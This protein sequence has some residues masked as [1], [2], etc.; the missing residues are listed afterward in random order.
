MTGKLFWGKLNGANILAIRFAIATNDAYQCVLECF[1]GA[2][3]ELE[4][5]FVS[6][7][8]WMYS[9]KQ[10][11]TRALE[12]GSSVQHSPVT[13]RDLVDLEKSGCSILIVACYQWKIPEWHDSIKYAV[14]FH[15][16]PLPEGRGPYPLVRALIDARPT[17]AVSCH[18]ITAK[19]DEGDILDSEHFLISQDECHESL[20][21]KIALATERLAQRVA[22]G[23]EYLWQTATPQSSGS[24]WGRWSDQDRTI[25]FNQTVETIMRQIRAFGDLECVATVNNVT[26]FVH[27]A[28]GWCEMPRAI[29][30]TVVHSSN[31]TFIVAASDGLIAI[32]EWSFNAP[33]SVSAHIRA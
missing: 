20:R 29:P 2:G 16:S 5:L 12:L 9:N 30:G 8:N 15:P 17:W 7:D 13:N 10:V 31:L 14:N 27:R 21:L 24:Y 23:M 19:F 4:R 11:I 33:G 26:I 18:K 22:Y 28:H 6:P 1:L 3:W 32:T 25:D